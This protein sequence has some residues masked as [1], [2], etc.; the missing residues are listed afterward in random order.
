MAGLL[1]PTCGFSWIGLEALSPSAPHVHRETD[2]LYQ[3]FGRLR[4]VVFVSYTGEVDNEAR[5]FAS[6]LAGEIASCLWRICVNSSFAPKEQNIQV[7]EG[8][9]KC[10]SMEF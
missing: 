9:A 10:Y 1:H 6:E 4:Q 2:G 7:G 8:L 5:M 3:R